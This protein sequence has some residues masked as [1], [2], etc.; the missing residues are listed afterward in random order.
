M[1]V[2]EG[3][4]IHRMNV[5]SRAAWALL[6]HEALTVEALSQTLVA[7]FMP[8][9]LEQ[10]RKDMAELLGQFLAVG[11]IEAAEQGA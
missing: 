6:Q 3:G 5:T 1:I 9:S 8:V 7:F 11:L 2:E 10:V 4:A